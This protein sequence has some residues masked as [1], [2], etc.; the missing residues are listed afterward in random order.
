MKQIMI[1]FI[2][3]C[4]T[5]SFANQDWIGTYQ[6]ILSKA[7]QQDK[8]NFKNVDVKMFEVLLSKIMPAE[9]LSKQSHEQ[10][11]NWIDAR[12]ICVFSIVLKHQHLNSAMQIDGYRSK[13]FCH[14][15]GKQISL[16]DIETTM[17]FPNT[18]DGNVLFTLWWGVMGG[19]S[20]R[21]KPYSTEMNSKITK[22][23]MKKY[24]QSHV[25][26]NKKDLMIPT[27]LDWFK[28]NFEKTGGLHT[29]LKNNLSQEK[30][31]LLPKSENR[32]QFSNFD[33]SFSS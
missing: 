28:A 10:V 29:F 6:D 23:H 30:K 26:V 8:V 3:V 15:F 4:M 27:F 20:L 25:L 9:A 14:V 5:K 12:N 22:E 16:N 11:S 1:L 7:V 31:M 19:P 21:G 18:Q 17:I 24:L 2:V 32:L 33:W 13:P